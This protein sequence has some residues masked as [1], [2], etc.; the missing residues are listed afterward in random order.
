[1]QAKVTILQ[2]AKK[3]W[4]SAFTT[5]SNAIRMRDEKL[6]HPDTGIVALVL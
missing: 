6:Y 5:Y 3:A 4:I 2:S 1:L